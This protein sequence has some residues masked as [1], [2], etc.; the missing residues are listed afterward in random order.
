[1]VDE[2]VWKWASKSMDDPDLDWDDA[3]VSAARE[4][5]LSNIAELTVLL[6][7]EEALADLAYAVSHMGMMKRIEMEHLKRKSKKVV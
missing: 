7:R 2:V 5:G 3:L 1:M 6:Y 4:L